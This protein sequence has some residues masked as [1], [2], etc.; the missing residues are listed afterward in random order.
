M[1]VTGAAYFAG[2]ADGIR[3]FSMAARWPGGIVD[4]RPFVVTTITASLMPMHS[5]F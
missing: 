5:P 2:C 3:S 1:V 4:G